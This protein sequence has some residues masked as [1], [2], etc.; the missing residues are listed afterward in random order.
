MSQAD[1]FLRA[2]HRQPVDTTPIWLMRQAGRYMAEYRALRERYTILEI[3][4]TPDL[5]TEVTLQ[6]LKAFDLDAGII[7]ADILPILA[8]L[9][10]EL[11][12]AKGEGPII[13]NP[14]RTAAD[15]A[16]LPTVLP[17]TEEFLGFTLQAIKQVQQE[18]AG[19]VPLIGFSGAPF[20]LASY[21]IEGGSSR[22]YLRAK[23]LM[24]HEP[25]LW[26]QLMTALTTLVA[27]YLI[28][29][30][31]AGAQA[32]QLFDSW[33][34]AL[35]PT[36]YRHY[37]LPYSQRVIQLVKQAVDVPLIHFGTGTAGILPLL[38]EVGGDV[39]G[40]DWRI[41][42]DVAWE[43]LGHEVVIQGNLDPVL[44]A[45]AP[46]AEIKRQAALILEQAQGRPGHIF[47]L[48]HGILQYT[49]PENV[50]A[51]VDFVH[52]YQGKK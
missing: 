44:L 36:D 19:R 15:F 5:A 22:D 23:G 41:D 2:C 48:G 34:G 9:G 46:I 52:T 49:P 13:H 33:I 4:K 45:T 14:L 51:L 11:T 12:F 38:K 28:A 17:P 47:N 25:Q 39:I 50:A 43:M 18:L 31:N 3:I 7:F 35:S 42:L 1:R 40:V 32:L 20:T 30:A 37:V 16:K 6:P 29:Q 8:G 27:D 26:Q 21:A 24:Y 10:L